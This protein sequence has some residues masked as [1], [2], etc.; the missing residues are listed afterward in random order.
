[1]NNESD[2]DAES[3]DNEETVKCPICL[4]KIKG[5]IIGLPEVCGHH[6]CLDCI[7]EWS[8]VDTVT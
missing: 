7:Q 5:Q 4:L 2:G 3:S 1:M 8:K 6:F